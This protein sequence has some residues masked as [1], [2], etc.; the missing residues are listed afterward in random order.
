VFLGT[1]AAL[2]GGHC[3]F[4]AATRIPTPKRMTAERIE[5]RL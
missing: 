5:P 4:D 1:L 3:W 2:F